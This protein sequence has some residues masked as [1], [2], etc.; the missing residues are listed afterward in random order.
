LVEQLPTQN[1]SAAK[2]PFTC[3]CENVQFFSP[4]FFPIAYFSFSD[5][6]VR[7]VADSQ[8]FDQPLFFLD[9]LP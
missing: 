1:S 4:S 9:R 3:C 7:A 6:L 2:Y 8:T 5:M